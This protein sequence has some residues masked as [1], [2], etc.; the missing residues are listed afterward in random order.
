MHSHL[1]VESKKQTNKQKTRDKFWQGCGEQETLCTAGGN[2]NGA[3]TMENSM[4]LP[5]KIKYRTTI[6]SSNPTSGH[7]FEKDDIRIQKR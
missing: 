5:Q 6:W 1:Y 7:I 4:E 3:A 2:V